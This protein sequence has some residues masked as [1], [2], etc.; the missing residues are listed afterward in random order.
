MLVNIQQILFPTDFSE[1]ARVAQKYA[2]AM[3]EQ[4]GASLHLLH[5][6]APLPAGINSN[7]LGSLTDV[8]LASLVEAGRS[9]LAKEIDEEWRKTHSTT[10]TVEIGFAVDEISQYTKRHKIDLIVMGTH[11]RSGLSHLLLG[12]VSEKIVRISECPVL[13]VHPNGRQIVSDLSS[14]KKSISG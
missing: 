7:G 4:F 5:V 11:G 1:P 6:V 13:T 8:D 10:L 2:I 12:S 3:A 9:Q 14:M